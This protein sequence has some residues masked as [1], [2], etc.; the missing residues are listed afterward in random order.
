[1]SSEKKFLD[2]QGLEYLWSKINMQ[3]Y[4]N[5]DALVAIIDAID[6]SKADKIAEYLASPNSITWNGDKTAYEYMTIE[7]DL[8]LVKIAGLSAARSA[9]FNIDAIE[10]GIMNNNKF[11]LIG[12]GGFTTIG[13]NIWGNEEA[14]VFII[15]NSEEDAGLYCTV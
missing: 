1:M 2:S 6:E 4:P 3:D 5:N 15:A 11:E 9:M 7:E 14:G 8:Y 12:P 10:F 13:D